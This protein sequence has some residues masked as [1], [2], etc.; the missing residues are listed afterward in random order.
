MAGVIGQRCPRYCFFGDTVNTSSRMNSNGEVCRTV[1]Y[2]EC[3]ELKCNG[4]DAKKEIL[5]LRMRVP[6][7]L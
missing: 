1:Q 7:S 3:L 6:Y 5:L 4:M 2:I